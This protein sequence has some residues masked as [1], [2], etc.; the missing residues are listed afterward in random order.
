[1]KSYSTHI[2]VANT[3]LLALFCLGVFAGD[4]TMEKGKAELRYVSWI[5]SLSFLTHVCLL[6][7]VF[8]RRII[9]E[10]VSIVLYKHHHLVCAAGYNY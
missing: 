7:N 1:M 5:T 4:L 8:A 2:P 10:G 9:C 6:S 3:H